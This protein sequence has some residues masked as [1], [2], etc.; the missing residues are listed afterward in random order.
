MVE[1]QV[2]LDRGDDGDELWRRSSGG[3][4]REKQMERPLEKAGRMERWLQENGPKMGRQSREIRSNVT[5]NESAIMGTSHRTIQG[6]NG[7]ALVDSRDQVIIHAEAF[8]ESQESSSDSCRPGW[9]ERELPITKGSTSR[10]FTKIPFK[11]FRSI[12]SFYG[13]I[14][15]QVQYPHLTP[16]P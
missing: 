3:A 4:E 16:T 11:P 5:D 7:Q 15:Y 14:I 8:G 6:Y 1:E 13:D 10:R 2:K 9:R 12:V